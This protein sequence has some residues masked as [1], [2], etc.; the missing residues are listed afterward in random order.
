MIGQSV[1]QL[2]ILEKSARRDDPIGPRDGAVVMVGH[3]RLDEV[4]D[5]RVLQLEDLVEQRPDE[6]DADPVVGHPHRLVDDFAVAGRVRLERL[7]VVAEI[8]VHGHVRA[9]PGQGRPR[10][11]QHRRKAGRLRPQPLPQHPPD[12]HGIRA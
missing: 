12:L 10:Q 6:V 9:Q 3:H 8:P 11:A 5:P 7:P 4:L 1:R 2:M